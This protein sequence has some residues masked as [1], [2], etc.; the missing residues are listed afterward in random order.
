MK[1]VLL[2]LL[3]CGL[4]LTPCAATDLFA[5]AAQNAPQPAAAAPA[6]KGS[7]FRGNPDTKIYHNSGCRY[8]NGKGSSKV[9]PS[10]QEAVK[11]GYRPCKVCKG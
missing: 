5:A 6:K 3:F 11:A 8:F 7:G 1:R 2:S 9:F 10:A 4:L